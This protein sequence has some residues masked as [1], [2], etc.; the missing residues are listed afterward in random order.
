LYR[1]AAYGCS[2]LVGPPV[3]ATTKTVRASRLRTGFL[4]SVIQHFDLMKPLISSGAEKITNAR[5][6]LMPDGISM[7][8][9]RSEPR[10]LES[11]LKRRLNP[12][13]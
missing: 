13:N 2:A 5:S 6:P 1:V 12:Q 11:V 7:G 8:W 10:E 4:L 3:R 9:D